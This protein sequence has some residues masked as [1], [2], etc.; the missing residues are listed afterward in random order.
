MKFGVRKPSLTRMLKARTTGRLKRAVKKEFDPF[1]G[2]KGMGYIKNPK[3][4][5]YNKVYHQTTVSAKDAFASKQPTEHQVIMEYLKAFKDNFA[6]IGNV[7]YKPNIRAY[8]IRPKDNEIVD[9]INYQLS[10][11]NMDEWA[12]TKDSLNGLSAKVAQYISSD[13]AIIL[14]DPRNTE[15]MLYATRNGLKVFDIIDQFN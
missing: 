9:G 12:D 2:K 3:R 13:I 8:I 15:N 5:L 4:A 14:A 11:N 10:I 7:V 1:Y 6:E